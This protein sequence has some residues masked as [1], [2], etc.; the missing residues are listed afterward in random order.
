LLQLAPGPDATIRFELS[1]AVEHRALPERDAALR[2]ERG[3]LPWSLGWRTSDQVQVTATW[4]AGARLL[5]IE[6]YVADASTGYPRS[7]GPAC[8]F[9]SPLF[10]EGEIDRLPGWKALFVALRP[11][12]AKRGQGVFSEWRALEETL[13]G[14]RRVV[15]ALVRLD[16]WNDQNQPVQPFQVSISFG[17]SSGECQ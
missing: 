5:R 16:T 10:D 2:D 9:S 15:L 7:E 17:P 14:G 3:A 8:G 6:G 1:Q 13:G 4:K 11:L 12:P